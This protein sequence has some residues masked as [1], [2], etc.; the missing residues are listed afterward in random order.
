[1][2]DEIF[3]KIKDN[4]GIKEIALEEDGALKYI[5]ANDKNLVP[6]VKFLKETGYEH[7]SFVT[8]VDKLNELEVVYLIHSYAQ[9]NFIPLKI[10]LSRDK[11]KTGETKNK[12]E[13]TEK[14]TETEKFSSDENFTV[15][16]LT[17]IFKSADWHER[18]TFDMFGIN[19]E[20]HK[21]L[22]RI[23]L[24]AKFKGYPLLK[25]YPSNK[26]QEI[27]LDSDFEATNDELTVDKFIESEGQEGRTYQTKIIHLN[28]GPHHPSTHG[29]LRLRMIIDGEKIIKIEPVIG[30]LHR[31]I[32]KICESLN[33]NQ[34][35]TYLDRLDYVASMLNEFPYVLAME[36]LMDIEVPER[37]QIIRV[38]TVELNRI[39]SHIMWFTTWCMDLGATTP[40]FYGFND[41]EKILEIFE[42]L[43]DA[44]MMFN[45]MCVG[46]VK[47]DINESIAKKIYKF[48]DTMP[49]HMKE[50]HNLITGNEIFLARTKNVG[51][52]KKEDALNLGVTGPM[53]RASGANYDVRK[54]EPYSMYAQFKFNVPVFNDGD[55]FS[56]YIVRMNEIEESLKII[57]QGMDM[58]NSIKEG[59]IK[60]KVPRMIIPPKRSVYT[61]IE[62]AKGEMGIFII[63]D[64]KPKPHRFKIQSPSFSN[65]SALPKMCENNYIADVVAISGTI[66]PVMGCVDR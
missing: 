31:G 16:T 64:G 34:I 38:I 27:S 46:G 2:I 36:K 12:T 26:E 48:T 30:Y 23:L 14:K 35:V 20:G 60:A 41:R 53:L 5:V 55:N 4:V 45:Y 24:P 63:S 58:L 28:V 10:K 22:R 32:E 50:Y 21:N 49:A 62:H 1:M 65:L 13:E 8:A 51:I 57:K 18:E 3:T 40:F 52:L 6:I 66:D 29:V 25:S 19:F 15:P 9:K 59:E 44:R 33:Y 37:A 56:R 54:D 43:S 39:A 42:D 47:K 11:S 7:L 61:K 17:E